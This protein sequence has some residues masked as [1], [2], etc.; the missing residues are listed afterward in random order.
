MFRS[1]FC[2]EAP[3]PGTR[4]ADWPAQQFRA[5]TVLHYRDAGGAG[6]GGQRTGGAEHQQQR[7][8]GPEPAPGSLRQWA[9]RGAQS[10]RRTLRPL[11]GWRQQQPGVYL[12]SRPTHI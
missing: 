7:C 8:C 10:Q 1:G 2:V 4:V 9:S 5:Q 3:S 12:P 6:Q 11:R